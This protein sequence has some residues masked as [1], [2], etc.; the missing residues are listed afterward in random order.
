[1]L[2][3]KV[4]TEL[5]RNGGMDS[6]LSFFKDHGAKIDLGLL[7]LLSALRLLNTRRRL[8]CK[9]RRS[10]ARIVVSLTLVGSVSTRPMV[11]APA[12]GDGAWL[13]HLGLRQGL[14]VELRGE[15][16]VGI[17]RDLFGVA[18][19]SAELLER[20][21]THATEVGQASERCGHGCFFCD[22]LATEPSMFVEIIPTF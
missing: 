18:S 12:L 8:G 16:V 14:S 20:L 13:P 21:A 10:E 9:C 15:V 11:V 2:Q 17:A 4:S 22:V 5:K 3:N 7:A 19:V 6:Y 1:L